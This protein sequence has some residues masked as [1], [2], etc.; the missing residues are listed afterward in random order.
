[1]CRPRRAPGMRTHAVT[2]SLPTSRPA[3]RSKSTSTPTQPPFRS[4]AA[5]LATDAARKILCQDTDPR[6]RSNNP[7]APEDL[8]PYTSTGSP[9]TSVCRR[10]RTTPPFSATGTGTA[11]PNSVTPLALPDQAS[12]IASEVTPVGWSAD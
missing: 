10:R 6:A 8:A 5:A 2:E 3:T 11:G 1:M 7:A 4:A 9:R 12:I